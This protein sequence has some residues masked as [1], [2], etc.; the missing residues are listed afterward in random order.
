MKYFENYWI[1]KRGIKS[2]NYY[3]IINKMEN[4]NKLK[5]IAITNN[6]IESFHGK[7]EIYLPKDPT[8]NKR[9]FNK[10]E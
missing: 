10:Y 4:K 5:Y 6:I 1:K 7:I 9:V 2:I 3:D 8:N